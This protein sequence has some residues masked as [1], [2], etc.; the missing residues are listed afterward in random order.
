MK[1]VKCDEVFAGTNPEAAGLL[2][3]NVIRKIVNSGNVIAF[4]ATHNIK[5]TEL[6]KES[7][8][9]RNLNMRVDLSNN[10]VI[11]KYKIDVGLKK[12]SIAESI[13]KKLQKE[14]IIESGED[15]LGSSF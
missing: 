3:T 4:I 7:S 12:Q 2:S 6:E 11:H 1:K 5:P 8:L 9:L 10:N 13:V 14:G 15:I